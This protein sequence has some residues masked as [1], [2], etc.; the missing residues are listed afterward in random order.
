[1]GYL[2]EAFV[3]AYLG[4]TTLEIPFSSIPFLFAGSMILA[5]ALARFMTVFLVPCIAYLMRKNF[6][7]KI[8][9]L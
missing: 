3:F 1:V 8:K 7:L 2:A 4:I 5:L 9:E 6:Y